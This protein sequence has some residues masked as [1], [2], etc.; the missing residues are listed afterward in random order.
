MNPEERKILEE[1]LALTKENN[2]MLRSLKRGM[3][4]GRIFRIGYWLVIA[5]VAVGAYYY[6][7]PYVGALVD[8]FL[9]VK[10]EIESV[11][12]ILR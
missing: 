1:N 8:T 2:E 7:E 10:A 11:G 6:V 4:L 9:G 3:L 5:G 12:G